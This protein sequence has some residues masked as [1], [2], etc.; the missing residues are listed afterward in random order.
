MEYCCRI[1]VGASS[2]VLSLLDKVQRRIVNVIGPILAVNIQH[3]YH[4]RKVASL[5]LFYKY[6]NGVVA[7][8]NFLL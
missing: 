6:F 7:L 5:S 1:W 2:V 4:R 3:F 8:A